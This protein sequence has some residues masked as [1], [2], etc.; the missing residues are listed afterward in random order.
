MTQHDFSIPEPDAPRDEVEVWLNGWLD[1]HLPSEWVGLL[2]DQDRAIALEFINKYRSSV[3]ILE[4]GYTALAEAIDLIN[5]VPKDSWPDHRGAQYLVIAENVK[6]FRSA[7]DRLMRGYYQ[8]CGSIIRSLYEVSVRVLFMS[9]HSE[10]WSSAISYRTPKGQRKFNL[11]ALLRDELELDW[12]PIYRL[13]SEVSHSNIQSVRQRIVTLS[14][15]DAEIRRYGYRNEFDP[16]QVNM[17]LPVLDF[18]LWAHLRL[19]WDVILES[20]PESLDEASHVVVG[21]DSCLDRIKGSLFVLTPYIRYKSS[22]L[23]SQAGHDLDRLIE[24]MQQADKGQDWRILL[25]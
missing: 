5:F 17:Y 12:D 22:S 11:T 3:E 4:V 25:R 21:V 8:D 10:D 13:L 14:V 9:L 16:V 19:V 6:S 1:R 24:M 20:R 23:W 2:H 15:T 7:Q 18:V